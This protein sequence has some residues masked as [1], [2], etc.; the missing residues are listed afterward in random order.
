MKGNREI[1]LK[2]L[3]PH[4]IITGSL[5]HCIREQRKAAHIYIKELRHILLLRNFGSVVHS[6]QVSMLVHI[7]FV[8]KLGESP[9]HRRRSQYYNELKVSLRQ[10]RA[11]SAEV[12]NFSLVQTG[13]HK[14]LSDETPSKGL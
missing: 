7:P 8:Q 4:S 10:L 1:A 14:G 2:A 6:Q 12:P 11:S 3:S 5:I 13:S 9:T